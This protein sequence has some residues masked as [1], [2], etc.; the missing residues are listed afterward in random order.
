VN[1]PDGRY[2]ANP[3]S[4][5]VNVLS[6]P[7][8]ATAA[9]N[10]ALA[11]GGLTVNVV[12]L[13]EGTNAQVTVTGSGFTR[14]LTNSQTIPILEPGTYTITA[15]DVST[16]DTRYAATPPTQSVAVT[17]GVIAATS[18]LYAAA[19]GRLAISILGLPAGS[20]AAV[21]VLGPA[22]FSRTVTASTTLTLLVPGVYQ[23]TGSETQAGNFTYRGAAPVTQTI[24]VP[25]SATPVNA[26]VRYAPID[27]A[28][29]VTI[30]G[31]PSGV[32]AN[33]TLTGPGGFSTT[34]KANHTQ[35]RLPP[36]SYTVSAAL[37]LTPTGAFAAIPDVQ[38]IAINA[39]AT[40]GVTL[41][42]SPSISLRLEPITNGL[43]RPVQ[44]VSPPNDNTRLIILEQTG[45]VRLV[46]SGQL[47][48]APFLDLTTRVFPP[49]AAADERGALGIVFH[50]QY[51]SNGAFF[52]Y[53][54]D[55]T[56][57]IVIDRFQISGN[58]DV[59]LP[60]GT[61]VLTLAKSDPFHNGGALAF[62]ADGLL[63]VGIGDGACCNDPGNNGQALNTLFGKILRINVDNPPY[64]V[65]PTNPFVGQPGRMPEIWAY[66]LRNPWRI[67]PDALSGLLYIADVGEDGFEEVNVFS[68]LQ[69]GA[70][71]GW[72]ITEGPQCRT[73]PGCNTAGLTPP[74]ISYNHTQGC[75]I[76]GGFVYRGA[77]IPE[78]FGH[79]FYSDFCRGFLRSFQVANGIAT[80]QRDWGI[81][82]PGSVTSFGEDA[83]GE[84]YVL[85]IAGGV[86]K[87]VKQ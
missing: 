82:S 61:R 13:T 36:G 78:L 38:V 59:A 72:N 83:L 40:A 34:I 74:I 8:P 77:A 68:V 62:G 20:N 69:G 30:T 11:T 63:Y 65:P 52:V 49:Q 42:Y 45:L 5:T 35:Q 4:Q 24:Q 12:G 57:S 76:T 56:H 2:A 81:P 3:G 37:V 17:P 44:L 32:D 31:L 25:A 41:N 23:V 10:Y 54:I 28:L 64:S 43:S 53:Y 60:N 47:M 26:T 39:G 15:T 9:V 50:P 6:G 33:V 21:T 46:K 79:Y 58:P 55:Q 48:V 85:T 18:V 14:T 1:T 29:N 22:S 19:T 66:G 27:G 84:L 67:D 87:I 71:F 75:S 70:N 51:A 16:A 73:A 7:N 80:Q 86:F